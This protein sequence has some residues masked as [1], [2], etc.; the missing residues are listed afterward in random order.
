VG[1]SDLKGKVQTVIGLIDPSELGITLAHEHLLSDGSCTF[2]EPQIASERALAHRPV[3]V[4]ILWWVRYHMNQNLDNLLQTDEQEAIEE[5]AHFRFAGGASVV[6]L[7]SCGIGRDPQAL[8]RISRATNVHVIMGCGYYQAASHGPEMD[9]KDEGEIVG[10]I[11]QDITAGVGDGGIHAGIIGE[12][13]CSWPMTDN[14]QKSLRASAHAQRLTG[15]ALNVHPGH[16]E[17]APMEIIEVLRDCRADLTRVVISHMERTLRDDSRRVQ[18]AE[19]GCY[20]E[21]DTFGREGYFQRSHVGGARVVDIPND[22]QRVDEII[23]LIERGYLSQI[24]VSQDMWTKAKRRRYGGWGY[25]HILRNVVPLMRD[26]GL[27]DEQIEAILV[28]N[29]KRL[30]TFV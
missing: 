4:D 26:K 24:L 30:L 27:T 16:S 28:Q 20:L 6:E 9:T 5:L 29:P 22:A 8:S 10:E 25:D 3:S 23:D 2:I 21:Y 12:I 14:E 7:T 15:A 13:G 1:G 19:T 11:V 18:L 17:K